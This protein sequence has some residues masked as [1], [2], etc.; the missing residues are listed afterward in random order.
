MVPT[1]VFSV[2]IYFL[3]LKSLTQDPD[4]DPIRI[5]LKAGSVG[6]QA[7]LNTD[8]YGNDQKF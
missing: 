1:L 5:E 2:K 7:D 8:K 4:T 3:W 6:F